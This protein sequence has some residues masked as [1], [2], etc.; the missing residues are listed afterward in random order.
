M[1]K[2]V[3]QKKGYDKELK[4]FL[5]Q[6]NKMKIFTLNHLYEKF[7]ITCKKER[8]KIKDIINK[9]VKKEYLLRRHDGVFM[10]IYKRDKYHHGVI[11]YENP[12]KDFYTI[13]SRYSIDPAFPKKLIEEAEAI[14]F[15][16]KDEIPKRKDYRNEIVFTIDGA[17]A[18]DLDDAVSL[19]KVGKDYHLTVH[20]A[21]VSFY[22]KSNKKMDKEA[23]ERG[24]SIY[25]ID[26]VVP[27]LPKV[28][29]N[30]ICSLNA[31][32]DKLTFSVEMVISSKGDLIKYEFFEGI[33][34][35]NRRFTYSEVEKIINEQKVTIKDDEQYLFILNEMKELAQI[36]RKKRFNEGSIDFDVPELK[37]ICDKKSRPIEI[38][39]AERYFSHKIIEEFMLSANKAAA[40]FLEKKGLGMYRVH[41]E[42]NEEKLD[43]FRIIA[44]TVGHRLKPFQNSQEIH[45]FLEK[46]SG[47]AESYLLNTLLLRSMKQA[48]YH[49]ENIGHFG[50]GFSHYAHF[51]SP[52]R[53][54]PDLVVHRLIKM[55]LKNK[56]CDK[57]D[58]TFVIEAARQSSERERN[59]VEME[60]AIIKRKA[61]HFLKDKM[62][63]T[64]KGIVSGVIEAGV[65]VVLDDYGIE[66]MIVS[67]LLKGYEFD[68]THNEFHYG[69]NILKLGIGVNVKLISLNLKKE[70]ID[71]NLVES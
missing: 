50:L 46:I 43:Y 1:G 59:A 6:I 3:T 56:K 21:D 58:K 7:E 67:T 42:P 57:V 18:K 51:T 68:A 39:K 8:K 44:G 34:H 29:S 33:I 15:I 49:H 55:S 40:L 45:K 41:E 62:G 47:S 4:D 70:M 10:P 2:K 36:L 12:K 30:G 14:A 17:D 61:I 25:L 27:M 16:P 63:K 35:S 69:K 71:F 24:T 32:E 53:R 11:G 31:D 20:I 26:R 60:R 65:F 9:L 48:Y 64:F 13:C 23:L 66:G 38:I 54:Y 5:Y 22:V 37:I 28:I 19:K 52:I